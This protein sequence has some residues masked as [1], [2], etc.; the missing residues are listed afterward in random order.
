[1]AKSKSSDFMIAYVREYLDGDMERLFFD[2][3]FDHYLIEHYPKM[4][5]E[6]PALAECFAFY[7]SEEGVDRSDNLSDSEHK[8]LIR[9]QFNRFMAAMRDGFG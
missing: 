4:D 9:R 3:D 7:L 2:L 1:M 5:R 8:K 6:N